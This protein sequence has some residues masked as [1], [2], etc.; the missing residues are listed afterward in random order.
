MIGDIYI[1]FGGLKGLYQEIGIRGNRSVKC[2]DGTVVGSQ[3]EAD[4][5]HALLTEKSHP[6]SW[7]HTIETQVLLIPGRKY[8]ADFFLNG[9]LVV[10]VEMVDSSQ[11]HNGKTAQ[12]YASRNL[13]KLDLYKFNGIPVITLQQEDRFKLNLIETLEYIRKSMGVKPNKPVFT[14]Q[15]INKPIGHW[16]KN[17]ILTSLKNSVDEFLSRK[18]HIPLSLNKLTPHLEKGFRDAFYTHLSEKE[19]N[20][21]LKRVQ[22]PLIARTGVTGSGAELQI[23][24]SLLLGL[25]KLLRFTKG[26]VVTDTK[27]REI[28]L[29]TQS[30]ATSISSTFSKKLGLSMRDFAMSCDLWFYNSGGCL[31]KPAFQKTLIDKDLTATIKSFPKLS[32]TE[33]KHVKATLDKRKFRHGHNC[34]IKKDGSFH[35]ETITAMSHLFKLTNGLPPSNSEW[36]HAG[37]K[38]LNDMLVSYCKKTD[39]ITKQ[40]WLNSV[41][42]SKDTKGWDEPLSWPKSPSFKGEDI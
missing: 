37:L 26:I 11:E 24:R 25:I 33:W 35:E 28:G 40:D 18:G 9:T 14:T 12:E 30:G 7:L 23:N 21:L 31:D 3:A 15:Q 22:M 16:D 19:Q 1:H 41:G 27:A 8:T 10:E 38:N 17:T 20:N 29:D 2:N 32:F 5:Y 39:S 13:Q 42:V 6:S 36:N 34:W 4:L